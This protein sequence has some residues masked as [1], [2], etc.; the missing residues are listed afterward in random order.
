MVGVLTLLCVVS[1]S[2]LVTRVAR[3]AL[4]HTGLSDQSARFQARSAF[5]GAGFTTEES[6]RVVNH[7]VLLRIV[8]LVMLLGNAGI[9]TAVSSLIISFVGD[10]A[11]SAYLRV[12]VLVAGLVALW[13][14]ATSRLVDRHLSRLIEKALKRHTRLDVRDFA[15]LVHLDG[16]YRLVELEVENDD[17]LAGRTLGQARLREEGVVALGIR[18]AEGGDYVG[19]P[20]AATEVCA[21]DVLI[22]YG[23]ESALEALD[24]R[25]RGWTG[26]REHDEA[27]S[28]QER[29]V[30]AEQER[31]EAQGMPDGDGGGGAARSGTG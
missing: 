23:R 20:Q 22:L 9:V 19:A 8:M 27:V 14:L 6:E 2:I 10:T 21:G 25:R 3:I 7:P 30:A 4:T 24:Q 1:L 31:E 26:D 12:L 16:E 29:V 5:T 18:R 17:W 28:E 13:G 15:S 11:G